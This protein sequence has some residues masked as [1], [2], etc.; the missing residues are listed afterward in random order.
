MTRPPDP[1]LMALASITASGP[2]TV[3]EAF[4]TS[5]L[6][7]WKSPPIRMVPPPAPPAAPRCVGP[8]TATRSPSTWIVPPAPSTLPTSTRPADRIVSAFETSSTVPPSSC[9]EVAMML[10]VFTT[11]PSVAT[12][13]TMPPGAELTDETSITPEFTMPPPSATSRTS[14]LLVSMAEATMMPSLLI[15]LSNRPFVAEAASTTCPPAAS[16][17]PEF[18]TASSWPSSFCLS[19]PVTSTFIRPSPSK[20]R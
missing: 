15:R 13:C 20:S 2:T 18:L 6:R 4:R 10:P 8:T 3:C 9:T 5:G 16:M 12:I 14:P 19:S 11:L 17:V 1:L 7:P